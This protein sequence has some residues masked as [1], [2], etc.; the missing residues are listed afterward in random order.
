MGGRIRFPRTSNST[1]V[2]IWGDSNRPRRSNRVSAQSS[3]TCRP[4]LRIWPSCAKCSWSSTPTLMVCSPSMN[5][6]LACKT[7][8]SCS[9]KMRS[10]QGQCCKPWM[11]TEMDRSTTR[12]SSQ[13]LSEKMCSCKVR[14]WGPPFQWLTKMEAIRLPRKSSSKSLEVDSPLPK[15]N[16]SGTISCRKSIRTKTVRS[17]SRSLRQP[18]RSSFNST[19]TL[20]EIRH[21]ES[22]VH[23]NP[24]RNWWTP[25]SWFLA[26]I[27]WGSSLQI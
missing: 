2:R 18:C 10:I 7:W 17:S 11:W 1:S 23:W 16:K 8:R 24:L 26:A 21:D 5:S 12:S 6:K 25:W 13:L 27:E 20:Q 3:R 4:R 22:L 19:P 9:S 15:V 14:I